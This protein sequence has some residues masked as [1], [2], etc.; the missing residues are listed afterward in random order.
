MRCLGPRQAAWPSPEHKAGP[1]QPRPHL[2]PERLELR[3]ALLQL[4]GQLGHLLLLQLDGGT[5]A[6]GREGGAL[7][8][9][10]MAATGIEATREALAQV[11]GRAGHTP[12][13]VTARLVQKRLHVQG[14]RVTV[15]AQERLQVGAQEELP[16]QRLILL[17]DVLQVLLRAAKAAPESHRHRHRPEVTTLRQAERPRDHTSSGLWEPTGLHG[18]RLHAPR[19]APHLRADSPVPWASA[20][21]EAPARNG[22]GGGLRCPSRPSSPTSP[23]RET[24][25]AHR[26][27]RGR[28][29]PNPLP[30]A[31]GASDSQAPDHIQQLVHEAQLLLG[32]GPALGREGRMHSLARCAR[33][34]PPT[35]EPH[36]AL[37]RTGSRPL[38]QQD[39]AVGGLCQS[40]SLRRNNDSSPTGG[41]Q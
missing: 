7:V 18:G 27:F 5:G 35:S 8:L 23:R 15:R 6:T 14:P 34:A 16:Q 32:A 2:R 21:S 37:L 33:S 40:Y 1:L 10:A 3:G 36:P 29:I 4:P 31:A 9:C 28:P 17:P 38:A 22:P 41:K 25:G 39:G 13:P 20:Q 19:P 11:R 12:P 30:G 26:P 24:K